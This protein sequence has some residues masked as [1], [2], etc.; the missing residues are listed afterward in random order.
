ME[1]SLDF[2]FHWNQLTLTDGAFEHIGSQIFEYFDLLELANYRQVC[3]SWR[4]FISKQS[5]FCCKVFARIKYQ[6]RRKLSNSLVTHRYE[7]GFKYIKANPALENQ[8]VFAD[9]ILASET[10]NKYSIGE[11]STGPVQDMYK[12]PI[13]T[14]NLNHMNFVWECLDL[15]YGLFDTKRGFYQFAAKANVSGSGCPGSNFIQV[16]NSTVIFVILSVFRITYWF[17]EQIA[18]V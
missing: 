5:Y 18:C 16:K 2:E 8:V 17:L 9:L 4:N 15:R 11:I 3:T 10:F 1:G 12:I 13:L 6:F 7:S 14:W